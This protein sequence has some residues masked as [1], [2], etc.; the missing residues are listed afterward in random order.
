VYTVPLTTLASPVA[1]VDEYRT[2][3]PWTAAA[4]SKRTS[5]VRTT[6]PGVAGTGSGAS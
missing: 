6:S 1:E 2:A 5:T 3:V 4:L